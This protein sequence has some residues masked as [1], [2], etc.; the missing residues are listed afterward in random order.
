MT[1]PVSRPGTGLGV[2]PPGD[3]VPIGESMPPASAARW[4][5]LLDALGE[6][7]LVHD[8]AGT[9][10]LANR[11][12]RALLPRLAADPPGGGTPIAIGEVV[13]ALADAGGAEVVEATLRG[14]RCRWRRH[15]IGPGLLAWH[16]MPEPAAGP[17]PDPDAA[18][19]LPAGLGLLAEEPLVP[20][21]VA[22]AIAALAVPA[23]ADCAVVVLPAVR[24][25]FDWWRHAAD[26]VAERG[27][28]NQ[29]AV[30]AVPGLLDL[31]T[32]LAPAGG[33]VALDDFDGGWLPP[34]NFGPVRGVLLVPLA[35][36]SGAPG[37]LILLNRDCPDQ[38]PPDRALVAEFVRR[39]GAAL[40]AALR[41]REQTDVADGLQSSLLP[42]PLPAVPGV[43]FAAVYRP[44]RSGLRVGGDFYDVHPQ[45]DGSTVFA[46]GDACGHGPDAASLAG[47]VRSCLG[48]LRLVER[49]PDRLLTLLNRAISTTSGS[50]F[51]T[52]VVGGLVVGDDRRVRL[53]LASAGHPAPLVLRAGGAVEEVVVAGGLLGVFPDVRFDRTAVV[54]APTE[55]CLV[56]SDG[57]TEARRGDAGG[58]QFGTERLRA[59]VRDHAGAPA[60]DLV[61][62][63]HTELDGW[64]AGRNHDDITLLAIQAE[65]EPG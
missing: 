38:A 36:P 11:P 25:R 54:L 63:V 64:L 46:L 65:P 16:A 30:R 49:A 43:R 9:I 28:V 21:R 47:H 51:T 10:L 12:A 2:G 29:E 4:R 53:E 19:G 58:E 23:L 48:A 14:Q 24:G 18:V 35:G 61:D 34:R 3:R 31:V 39:A 15:V 52:A 50:R 7:I 26:G 5:A 42:R 6:A 13:P 55:V 45:D 1:F 56:Y 20:E 27:R 60:D 32:E 8:G 17:P 37:A 41:L 44:A 62:A 57:V 22:D 33:A 40:G 59:I